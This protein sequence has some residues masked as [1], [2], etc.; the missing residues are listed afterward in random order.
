MRERE[1]DGQHARAELV[2]RDERRDAD[3]RA[4]RRDAHL[5]RRVRDEPRDE[6]QQCLAER[7]VAR[8]AARR[9]ANLRQPAQLLG[10]RLPHE[11]LLV[12]RERCEQ[13]ENDLVRARKPACAQWGSGA[14]S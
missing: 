7:R 5:G 3:E 14:G 1:H 13:R 12:A 9:L 2:A 6:R 11:R 10:Q 4:A 8:R